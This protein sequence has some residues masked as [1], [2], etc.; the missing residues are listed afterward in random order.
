[1][2]AERGAVLAQV[3]PP[4]AGLL[5][6]QPVEAVRDMVEQLHAAFA[7]LGGTLA[8]PFIALSFLALPLIPSLKITDKGLVDVDRFER[9]PL[10]ADKL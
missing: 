3:P 10:W 4:I 9:V 5:S 8:A 1:V 7:D 2:V 6:D